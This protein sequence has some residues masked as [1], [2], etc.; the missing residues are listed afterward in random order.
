MVVF[1]E[2]I[3]EFFVDHLEEVLYTLTVLFVVEF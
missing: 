1:L 2:L 3:H